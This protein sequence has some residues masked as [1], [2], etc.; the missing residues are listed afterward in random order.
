MDMSRS[1]ILGVV[2]YAVATA[3]APTAKVAYV[4]LGLPQVSTDG[5]LTYRP[6]QIT[7]ILMDRRDVFH[8]QSQS[9]TLTGAPVPGTPIM[10]F[11]NG[12][13]QEDGRDYTIGTSLVPGVMPY[14]TVTFAVEISE[15][16]T[17]QV[18]YWAEYH[19]R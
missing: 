18:M 15:E 17:I 10:V 4:N 19:A 7:Q 3:Q 9:Y 12:L 13:L 16:P 14:S 5:G 2:L 8:A 1:L 11:L 6:Q